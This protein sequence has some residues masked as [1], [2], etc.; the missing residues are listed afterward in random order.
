MVSK[1]ASIAIIISTVILLLSIIIPGVIFATENDSPT[2]TRLYADDLEGPWSSTSTQS[3][4]WVQKI[5]VVDGQKTIY[6]HE[7]DFLWQSP[8][9]TLVFFAGSKGETGD[10]GPQGPAGQMPMRGIRPP[11]LTLED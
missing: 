9:D 11:S 5:T 2:V 8:Q 4:R 6:I 7:V 3:T 1:K 10:T